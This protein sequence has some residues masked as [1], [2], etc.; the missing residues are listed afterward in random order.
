MAGSVAEIMVRVV[1]SDG[2][3]SYQTVT[4]T[5]DNWQFTPQ[6]TDADTYLLIVEAWDAAGNTSVSQVFTLIAGGTST[7]TTTIYLPF[8]SK[9]AVPMTAS[10]EL[11]GVKYVV[12]YQRETA[13]LG[14]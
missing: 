10:T 7:N 8:V 9:G 2:T 6:L 1:A 11:Q 14:Q 4:R 5:G 12:V 3:M 13:V